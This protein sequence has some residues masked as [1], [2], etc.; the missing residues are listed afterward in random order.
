MHIAGDLEVTN[1]Y[2]RLHIHAGVPLVEMVETVTHVITVSRDK[3]ISKLL[4]D[5]THLAGVVALTLVDRFLMVEEWAHKANGLVAVAIVAK[6][7]HINPER[8]GAKLAADLGLRG[9]IFTSEHEALAWLLER[10][11]TED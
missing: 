2:C 10:T 6:P 8:F 4:V 5:V 7:E 3:N 11:S 9:D 1:G